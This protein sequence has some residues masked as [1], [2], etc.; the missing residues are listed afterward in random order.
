MS[1]TRYLMFRGDESII[2]EVVIKESTIGR[3][4]HGC[5]YVKSDLQKIEARSKRSMYMYEKADN[6]RVKG[7]PYL[8]RDKFLSPSLNSVEKL[9][10]LSE[11]LV[12][13]V[14]ECEP[15]KVHGKHSFRKKTNKNLPMTR[16]L[17]SKVN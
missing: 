10:K 6:H 14:E 5:V 2:E 3:S 17:W 12:E 7:S 13:V 4:D 9:N 8:D 15:K 16:K 1:V 11:R